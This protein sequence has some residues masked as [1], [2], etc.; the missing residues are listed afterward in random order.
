MHCPAGQ[1]VTQRSYSEMV[2]YVPKYKQIEN[3]AA[4]KADA[5][6]VLSRITKRVFHVMAI[7]TPASPEQ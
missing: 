4:V 1:I 2:L 7:G 5:V 6:K 3:T